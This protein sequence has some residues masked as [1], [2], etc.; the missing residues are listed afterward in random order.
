MSIASRRLWLCQHFMP[1]YLIVGHYTNEVIGCTCNKKD[2]LAEEP[3][4]TFKRVPL[5]RCPICRKE[6][7]K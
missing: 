5:W 1:H 7:D 6:E 3:L 2:V 4:A